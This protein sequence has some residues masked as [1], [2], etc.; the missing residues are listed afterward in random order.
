M[1]GSSLSADKQLL[2][3]AHWECKCRREQMRRKRSK[4]LVE[5]NERMEWEMS[6][7]DDL[8][9]KAINNVSAKLTEIGAKLADADAHVAYGF[10]EIQR[11]IDT[12]DE[13][14]DRR[15]NGLEQEVGGVRLVL[16]ELV[17]T[18]KPDVE[19]NRQHLLKLERKQDKFDLRL[20]RVERKLGI[21]QQ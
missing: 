15:L 19:A 4:Q 21:A 12:L 18:M 8:V 11:Q 3:G 7:G 9:L 10:G 5:T 17:Q 16:T 13:K 20:E 14:F 2:G 6:D 1:N